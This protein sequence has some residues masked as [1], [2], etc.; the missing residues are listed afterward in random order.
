MKDV[1]AQA[2]HF[3][4]NSAHTV[5]THQRSLQW[6]REVSADGGLTIMEAVVAA[7]RVSATVSEK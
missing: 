6:L 5:H 3:F 4:K 7:E 2:L 1:R